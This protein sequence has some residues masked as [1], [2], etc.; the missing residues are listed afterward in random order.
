M[1][2]LG[3]SFPS[4]SSGSKSKSKGNNNGKPRET[5]EERKARWRREK[6]ERL[7]GKKSGL[8]KLI[9]ENVPPKNPENAPP[10]P[11]PPRVPTPAQKELV[12]SDASTIASQVSAALDPHNPAIWKAVEARYYQEIH[13]YAVDYE[14]NKQWTKEK[15]MPNGVRGMDEAC[16][17][18]AKWRATALKNIVLS[19]DEEQK[20]DI[21]RIEIEDQIEDEEKLK[22]QI[23]KHD[24]ERHAH[25]TFLRMTMYENEIVMVDRLYKMGILW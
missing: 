22:R 16:H 4:G 2:S 6:L 23:T 7:A 9:E 3:S 8:A 12:V 17:N 11:D 5:P 18:F 15:R 19:I 25:R 20:R 10:Q 24:E 13:D 14:Y 21:Q 1:S